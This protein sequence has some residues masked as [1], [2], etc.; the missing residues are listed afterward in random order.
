MDAVPNRA[1]QFELARQPHMLTMT[2]IGELTERAGTELGGST[3]SPSRRRRSTPSLPRRAIE[4]QIERF[5]PGFRDRI[6]ARHLR[7][8]GQ[9]QAHNANYVGGDVVTGAN[10]PRQLVF[11][12][13]WRWTR[14]RPASRVS[15]CARRRHRPGRGARH[16]RLQRG[17]LRAVAARR[18]CRGGARGA[19]G[20]GV[21]TAPPEESLSGRVAL[22][23]GG[24]RGIGAA[25][26]NDLARRGRRSRPASRPIGSGP[27]HSCE[28]CP[29]ARGARAFTR[30][31]WATPRTRARR[32]RGDRRARPPRHSRQ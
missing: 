6:L 27:T 18:L 3:G 17:D 20:G 32:Q 7:S 26:G 24:T 25:I 9:M 28:R 10:S 21:M 29:A 13:P 22:V 8:V 30:A 2:R 15:T 4:G 1:P 11:R 5:A 12:P 31:T 14:I 16:V 23:T 19:H